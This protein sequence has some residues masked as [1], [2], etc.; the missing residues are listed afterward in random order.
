MKIGVLGLGIM[1]GAMSANLVKAGFTVTGFDPADEATA[2]FAAAGG[3]A[4]RSAREVGAASEIVITSLPSAAALDASIAGPSG[5][6]AAERPGLLIVET[7]TLPIPV[8]MSARDAALRGGMT[9]LDCPISGT[10]AQARNKDLSMYGSGDRAAYDRC[11]ELF[12]GFARSWFYLGEFGNGS[13]MKFI[14]NLLVS[15]HNVA[16]AEAMV[17]GERAGLSLQQV[18]D[19]IRDGAGNSRMFEVRGPM[20]VAG[21]YE[22]ATMKIDIWQ[23][24]IDTI[25]AFAQSIGSPTPTFDAASA[26]YAEALARGMAKLDTAATCQV[27]EGRVGIKR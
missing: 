26:V 6:A 3:K 11:I 17:M 20:M 9:M 7:S 1:G 21:R 19:V 8:K 25:S 22:P 27:L 12:K 14:A 10:G 15:T 24:D 5:L 13:K 4:V 23:K 2:A 16:A 18:Y